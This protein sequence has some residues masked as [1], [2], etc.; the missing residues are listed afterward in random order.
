M[1][2]TRKRCD[3][4]DGNVKANAVKPLMYGMETVKDLVDRNQTMATSFA[5]T[6]MVTSKLAVR[7]EGP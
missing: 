7:S 1:A 2:M 5:G 6:L 4:L 3:K